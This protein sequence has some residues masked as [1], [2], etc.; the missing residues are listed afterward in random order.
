MEILYSFVVEDLGGGLR[1]RFILE[2][3]FGPDTGTLNQA[4]R[5]FGRQA[6]VGIGGN[7]GLIMLGVS[8]PG[9]IGS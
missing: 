9:S 6:W 4:G 7:W 5:V 8:T 3:G 2:Q 1:V